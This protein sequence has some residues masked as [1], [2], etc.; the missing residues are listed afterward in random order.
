MSVILQVSPR[1]TITLPAAVRRK[2]KLDSAHAL[3]IMEERPDGIFL[4]PAIPV[5]VRDIP[6]KQMKKWIA[7]DEA[8]AAKVKILKR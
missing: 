8:A 6:A 5:P 7:D 2:L 3:V 4:H 1:G